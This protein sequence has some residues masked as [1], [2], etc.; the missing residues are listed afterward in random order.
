MQL[1]IRHVEASRTNRSFLR[2]AAYP[3][4]ADLAP[5]ESAADAVRRATRASR[6]R[7]SSMPKQTTRIGDEVARIVLHIDP[8]AELARAHRCYESHL[9]RAKWV[10]RH[11]YRHLA[12]PWMAEGRMKNVV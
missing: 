6:M 5:D 3:E 4:V 12:Q 9:A 2:A 10:A 8:D 11:G 1:G 7:V